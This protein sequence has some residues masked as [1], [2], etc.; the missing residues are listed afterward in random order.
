M[1]EHQDAKRFT[2]SPCTFDD[3]IDESVVRC[4]PAEARF[5]GVY[6][7]CH[8]GVSDHVE[9]FDTEA[10][11]LAYAFTLANGR[12]VYLFDTVNGERLA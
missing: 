5:W 10:E 2:V 4:A 7:V 6:A 1:S 3:G 9:D 8:G 12:A 11:A